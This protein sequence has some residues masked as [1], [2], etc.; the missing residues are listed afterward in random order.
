MTYTEE[1]YNNVLR[2]T[3]AELQA[4]RAQKDAEIAAK[5]AELDALP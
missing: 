4:L 1:E 2:S 5:Q 3:A